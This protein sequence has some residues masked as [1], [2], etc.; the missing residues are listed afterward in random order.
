M[1][2]NVLGTWHVLEAAERAGTVERVVVFSS[3]QVFGFAEG[4][5]GGSPAYLPVDD[6]HPLRAS[7]PYGLSKR[8]IEELCDG[9]TDRTGIP[10]VVLRPAMVLDDG[11]LATRPDLVASWHV[12]LDDVVDATLAALDVELPAPHVRVSLAATPDVDTSAAEHALQWR[13]AA[14]RS[15]TSAT[16]ES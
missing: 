1:A 11:E 9:W 5:H 16:R 4:E 6:A 13:P 14:T 10:T 15:S 8:L 3:M 7:R 12:R 2:T